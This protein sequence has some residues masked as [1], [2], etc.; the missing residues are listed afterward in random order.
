MLVQ[1]DVK[2]QC[3]KNNLKTI[4]YYIKIKNNDKDNIFHIIK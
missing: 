2:V 4:K 3:I 1:S